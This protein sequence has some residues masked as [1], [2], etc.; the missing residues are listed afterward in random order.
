MNIHDATEQAYKNG[1]EK[2]AEDALNG[3][4][5]IENMVAVLMPTIKEFAKRLLE[6]G[7]HGRWIYGEEYTEYWCDCSLCGNREWDCD[8]RS[9]GAFCRNCGAMMGLPEP[10]SPD[11]PRDQW[12]DRARFE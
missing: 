12:E 1:Y 5:C 11:I 7:K 9:A 3:A 8:E 2:G 6:E 10:Y 4:R